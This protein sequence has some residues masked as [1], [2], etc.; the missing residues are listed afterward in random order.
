MEKDPDNLEK[1]MAEFV[2]LQL[3]IHAKTA[4]MLTKLKRQTGKTDQSVKRTGC[5]PEI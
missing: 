4:P 2:D 3:Q 1:Y 5:D